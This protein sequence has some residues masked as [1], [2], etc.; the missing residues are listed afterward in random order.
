MYAEPSPGTAHQQEQ[1]GEQ[2]QQHGGPQAASTAAAGGP[3]SSA[4]NLLALSGPALLPAFQRSMELGGRS[5]LV[6]RLLLSTLS[7]KLQ[8]AG[9][10]EGPD[11]SR[12]GEEF[13]E[14]RAAAEAHGAQIVLGEFVHYV[15]M[16]W[17]WLVC[18]HATRPGRGCS[19][20][21]KY[22]ACARQFV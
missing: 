3:S 19:L 20:V 16:C 2:Q 5:A 9:G 8:A 11:A 7:S 10:P 18:R 4:P 1:E 17:R 13:R 22:K 12:S 21:I 15:G 6:L 14:A